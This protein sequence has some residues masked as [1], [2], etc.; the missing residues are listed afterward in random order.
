MCYFSNVL[1]PEQRK[2]LRIATTHLPKEV[3]FVVGMGLSGIAGATF[4]GDCLGVQVV[5][6]RK[7]TD[8]DSHSAFTKVQTAKSSLKGTYF[9]VDDLISTGETVKRVRQLVEEE[10][11]GTTC[12][13]VVIFQQD[14]PALHK[15]DLPVFQLN[16]SKAYYDCRCVSCT[17]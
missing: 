2:K 4:I 8:R 17:S 14:I 5:L 10:L 16:C 3:D 13:G 6:V 1:S 12:K 15:V 9:I 7:S 11:L